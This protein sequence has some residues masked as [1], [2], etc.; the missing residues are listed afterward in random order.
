[1]PLNQYQPGFRLIDGSQLNQ[2]VDVVNGLTG[3]S[4]DSDVASTTTG[5]LD[6][7]GTVT[8]GVQTPVVAAGSNSQAN[9]TAITKSAAVITTVSAT[10]RGIRLP[11]AATGLRI[12]IFNAAA[13]AV[14]PY[15]A[16]ND[17]IG[18]ASTN[19]AGTAIAAGKGNIYLAQS[20]SLW[21][22]ITGA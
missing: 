18:A 14:K 7:T 21:R 3:G 9:A 10:T 22:V 16:T 8:V 13:T 1:M 2:M 15:P 5:T 6:V 19:A 11:A 17:K 12:E 20:D 4:G